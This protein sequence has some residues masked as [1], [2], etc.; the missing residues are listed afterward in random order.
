MSLAVPPKVISQCESQEGSHGNTGGSCKS[1]AQIV[2]EKGFDYLTRSA[3]WGGMRPAAVWLPM[4][5]G[6]A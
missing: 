1:E 6:V 3:C 2:K 4:T 5:R